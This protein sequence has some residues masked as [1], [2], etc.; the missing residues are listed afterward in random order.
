MLTRQGAGSGFDKSD[1]YRVYSS[2]FTICK[3]SLT[4][5]SGHGINKAQC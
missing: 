2:S 3:T 1:F 4:T 5:G